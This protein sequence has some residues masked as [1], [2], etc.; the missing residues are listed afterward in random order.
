M[1]KGIQL[2]SDE[3]IISKIYLIRGR[4]V[5][6]DRDLALLYNVETRMLNQA[7]KRNEKRFPNGFMF[8][9]TK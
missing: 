1:A 9:M 2:I 7:V 5:M 3:P 6:I 4:K 8:Q